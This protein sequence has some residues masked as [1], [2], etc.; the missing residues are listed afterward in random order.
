AAGRVLLAALCATLPGRSVAAEDTWPAP[1]RVVAVGDVHGDFEAFVTVLRAAALVDDKLRWVGGQ[2]HL[3]QTGDRL[4]RGGESRKVMDLL[5]RLQKEAGKAGG[6]VHALTGNHEAMN[7]L[8]DLRYV[9]PEEFTAFAGGD[10]ARYR[11]ALWEQRVKGRR[12]KG[13][14]APSEADRRLF[15]EQH[16][17]GFVEHRLA[18]A[19]KGTYGAW[20]ARANAVIKLGDSLFLHGGLAPKYAD[21]SLADLNERVRRELGEADPMTAV[22]SQDQEGPLWYRGLAQGSPDLIPHLEAVLAR[23]GAKRMVIGHTPT[24]GLVLPRYGGRVVLIDVGLAKAYG[25]PPAA[26]VLEEGRTFALHRGR[27]LP[28]PEAE[29]EALLGYVR[30]VAALEPDSAKLKALVS[31]LEGASVAPSSR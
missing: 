5:M 15:D 19:P 6:R 16:P 31:R 18:F 29:G 25:G 2:A 12:D 10:S 14:A 9:A 24:E 28:L 3:V 4:D 1:A 13:E 11:D 23:H 30:E 26:L 27:K 8:G 22:V 20:I 17:L 7:M 21:F